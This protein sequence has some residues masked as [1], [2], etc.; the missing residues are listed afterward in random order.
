MVTFLCNGEKWDHIGPLRD[1]ALE[2]GYRYVIT[3]SVE[4]L[5]RILPDTVKSGKTK[6]ICILGG[7]GTIYHFINPL[8]QSIEQD[9]SP[10]CPPIAVLGGGTMNSLFRH[11]DGKGTPEEIARRVVRRVQ[12]GN[13]QTRKM[14]LLR[15]EHAGQ[16]YFG[17]TFCIGP[18]VRL[19][20][21]YT[22]E[23]R[24]FRNALWTAIGASLAST[25]GWPI[26]FKRLIHPMNTS[27]IINDSE[28]CPLPEITGVVVSIMPR[29]IFGFYP[30]MSNTAGGVLPTKEFFSIISGLKPFEIVAR[31]PCLAFC[32]LWQ[33]LKVN[34]PKALFNNPRHLNRPVRSLKIDSEEKIFTIDGEIFVAEPEQ[35]I[36][37]T[38]GPEISLVYPL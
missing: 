36:V 14:P 9:D 23:Q 13:L 30:F 26:S 19:L 32:G 8:L 34:I 17:F 18:I 27:V 11:L 6:V 20:K 7:D 22:D 16:I 38:Q 10:S 25:L 33:E 24:N 15:I 31:L 3:D 37:I 29:T 2:Y 28:K 12:R 5:G 4:D 21:K 35:P 1:L